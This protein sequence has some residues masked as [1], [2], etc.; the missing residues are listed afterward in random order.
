MVQFNSNLSNFFYFLLYHSLYS[1]PSVSSPFVP[2]SPGLLPCCEILAGLNGE[3]HSVFLQD[4]VQKRGEHSTLTGKETEARR[5]DGERN[6]TANLKMS[7][8]GLSSLHQLR[9]TATLCSFS[10][11][12]PSF[13]SPRTATNTALPTVAMAPVGV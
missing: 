11:F 7:K 3:N 6:N 5:R 1:L 9:P 2:L 10:F 13:K 8:C 4:C 12:S